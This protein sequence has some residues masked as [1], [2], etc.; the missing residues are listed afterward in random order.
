MPYILLADGDF[1]LGYIIKD[2]IVCNCRLSHGRRMVESASCIL[3]N[4]FEIL[5]T[6]ID[7]LLPKSQH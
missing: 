2:E 3:G 1:L 6:T 7:L 4:R 5:L